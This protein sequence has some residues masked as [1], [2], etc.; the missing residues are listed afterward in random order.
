MEYRAVI[1]VIS[2]VLWVVIVDPPSGLYIGCSHTTLIESYSY[3]SESSF[4]RLKSLT[5][6]PS[7][8]HFFK[9]KSQGKISEG[10]KIKALGF[11]A[12]PCDAM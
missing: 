7:D 12:S 5:S 2:D 3:D 9:L 6:L 11:T 1:R 4:F 8:N 10:A